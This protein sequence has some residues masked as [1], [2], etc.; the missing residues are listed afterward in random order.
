LGCGDGIMALGV[1]EAGGRAVVGSDLTD[2]FQTL[3]GRVAQALGPGPRHPPGLRFSRGSPGEPLPFPDGHFDA[4]YSWSVFEHVDGVPVLL[5]EVDAGAQ[6]GRALLPA[7][8]APVLLTPRFPPAAPGAPP[9]AHL[10]MDEAAYLAEAAAAT[11]QVRAEE[12][13]VLYQ[14]NAF[15]QVKRYL[16]GE[17][18]SLN[19]ITAAR[20]VA[21]TQEAGLHIERCELGQV[22]VS[23]VP[24][25]CRNAFPC[26]T[27]ARRNP[28]AAAQA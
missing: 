13:D 2:A 22:P 27:C 15:E 28:V 25:P 1:C 26:T 20:L 7:D 8:R 18:H 10:S 5:A 12:K 6:A 11:D 23:S 24:A 19:R 16:I 14:L 17:Y 4:G 21:Y 3:P 9:W